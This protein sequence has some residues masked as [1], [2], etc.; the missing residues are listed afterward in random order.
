L[1]SRKAHFSSM[2]QKLPTNE[3]PVGRKV[4]LAIGVGDTVGVDGYLDGAIVAAEEFHAWAQAAGYQCEL[5][6]DN[7]A[8][9]GPTLTAI[10]DALG[11]CLPFGSDTDRLILFFAG[12]GLA[13]VSGTTGPTW[14]P[15]DWQA[16]NACIGVDVLRKRLPK[17][18]VRQ[19]SI[20][21]DACRVIAVTD[22]MREL[23]VRG[24]LEQGYTNPDTPPDLDKF[25]AAQDGRA[26]FMKPGTDGA[27][28]RCIFS[29]VLMEGLWGGAVS[30]RSP[31]MVISDSL[32]DFLKREVPKRAKYYGQD[33]QPEAST[34][35]PEEQDIYVD[36]T[37]PHRPKPVLPAWPPKMSEQFAKV[38]STQIDTPIPIPGT[39]LTDM[40]GPML[41]SVLDGMSPEQLNTKIL[42]PSGIGKSL[43]KTA[44]IAIGKLAAEKFTRTPDGRPLPSIKAIESLEPA[45]LEALARALQENAT[46]IAEASRNVLDWAMAEAKAA[47][48]KKQAEATASDREAAVQ[49]M[50]RETDGLSYND[51]N[52]IVVGQQV[53]AIWGPQGYS[54]ERKSKHAWT[55]RD[56]GPRRAAQLL[57]ELD[58]GLFAS[59]PT[60]GEMVTRLMISADGAAA[61]VMNS[62]WGP[63][64]P[65]PNTPDHK[66]NVLAEEAVSQ[67]YS[68]RLARDA[69]FDRAV[70]LRMKKHANP[71]LGVISAYLYDSVGDRDSIRR[72]AWFY[73][74]H[75]QA[76]PYDI[77][78]LAE[79]PVVG[80]DE[81]Q[82]CV[83]VPAT[84]R[85]KANTASEKDNKWITR[86]TPKAKGRVAGRWPWLRQGWPYVADPSEAERMM[87]Y[88]VEPALKGLL[89]S[90]FT[91]L[92]ADAGQALI[93]AFS[94]TRVS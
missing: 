68:G 34:E 3:L 4:C 46:P 88:G 52:A 27:P 54:A 41:G 8:P 83:E 61:M 9:E 29:G 30:K 75:G 25:M 36:L 80:F 55:V 62:R 63:Y 56:P 28:S 35:F 49:D 1:I 5:L 82:L 26:A 23:E 43:A 93:S 31:T 24:L 89:S 22:E 72:M 12:H 85:R 69:T 58:N 47:L 42:S 48:E 64:P 86:A 33:L 53:R 39:S 70:D 57:V 21:S 77:A 2:T 17:F 15:K 18:G 67:L 50:L 32:R 94:M 74:Q 40:I 13:G 76:I 84:K 90:P 7:T 79:L 20:F 16:R 87:T 92:N 6:T 19:I 44:A 37:N 11:R 81:D 78:F 51:G 59:C 45:E 65:T 10:S 91:T 73:V 14:L 60:M 71:V 38:A 66:A